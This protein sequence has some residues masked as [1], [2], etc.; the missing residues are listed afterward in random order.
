MFYAYGLFTEWVASWEEVEEADRP[1]HHKPKRTLSVF[2]NGIGVFVVNI[3][4]E[5]QKTNSSDDAQEILR[6]LSAVCY[7]D[8][9]EMAKQ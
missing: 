7:P 5:S 8:G 2:F 4:P 6:Q 1:A 9:P 3:Q